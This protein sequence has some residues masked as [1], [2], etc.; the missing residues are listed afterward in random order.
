MGIVTNVGKVLMMPKGEW[1]PAATYEYLDLVTYNGSKW[2]CKVESCVGI[3]PTATAS[4]YWYP[5]DDS[6]ISGAPVDFTTAATRTDIQ[7]GELVSTLFG[8]IKRWLIDLKTV[9]FTGKM[10]DLTEFVK[11]TTTTL[12][13]V[14]VDGESITVDEDGTIHGNA[15]VVVDSAMSTT[16][17]N[18]LQNK[19]ISNAIGDMSALETFDKTSIV[20]AVNEANHEV[21]STL[22]EVA[23]VTEPGKVADA[24]VVKEMNSNLTE[25]G[26]RIDA[27]L[28]IF[29][30]GYFNSTAYRLGNLLFISCYNLKYTDLDDFIH[31]AC[32]NRRTV[33]SRYNLSSLQVNIN[34]KFY[35]TNIIT[36]TYGEHW[37]GNYIQTLGSANVTIPDSSV[38]IGNATIILADE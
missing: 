26:E 16:S 27:K 21:L 34:Q 7:S 3:E 22:E 5:Y 13:T 4:E 29:T 31:Q 10:S 6:N 1:S 38:L 30:S 15:A 24:L 18:P 28:T 32:D 33:D 37:Q 25:L 11:A 20:A 35:P 8:K 19:V 36:T 23:A 12:G 14:K 2:L 17:E 9:A